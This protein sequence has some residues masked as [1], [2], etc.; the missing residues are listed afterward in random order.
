MREERLRG[1]VVRVVGDREPPD[2]ELLR[3][4]GPSDR[5]LESDGEASDGEIA[6]S[7]SSERVSSEGEASEGDRA[8]REPAD[9]DPADG[10]TT[11]RKEDAEGDVSDGD[12]SARKA[13]LPDTV[14]D[15]ARGHVDEGKPQK[16]EARTVAHW[17]C[18]SREV[19]SIISDSSL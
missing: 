7:E 9:R 4:C 17:V 19:S 16:L 15:G 13:A 5:T 10:E 12:P 11:R 1:G 8:E 14:L 2:G 18:L 6:E 3:D